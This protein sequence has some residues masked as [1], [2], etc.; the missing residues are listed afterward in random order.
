MQRTI[1]SI[2]ADENMRNARTIKVSLDKEF[3]AGA[4]WPGKILLNLSI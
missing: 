3:T 4:P 1:F 2:L